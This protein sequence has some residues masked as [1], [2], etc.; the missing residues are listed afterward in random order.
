MRNTMRW[1]HLI[2]GARLVLSSGSSDRGCLLILWRLLTCFQRKEWVCVF[3][4]QQTVWCFRKS[5]LI[6]VS[7]V[8]H[9]LLFTELVRYKRWSCIGNGAVCSSKYKNTQQR[10]FVTVE[11]RTLLCS[12]EIV[13][14]TAMSEGWHSLARYNRDYH[15]PLGQSTSL[16]GSISRYPALTPVYLISISKTPEKS[17]ASC[18]LAFRHYPSLTDRLFPLKRSYARH[19]CSLK[20]GIAL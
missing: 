10:S 12:G 18:F 13:K 16:Q 14:Y 4:I 7:N 6:Y 8:F 9:C 3:P 17:M 20:N 15:Y 2:P 11:Y 5:L 1:R 19:D